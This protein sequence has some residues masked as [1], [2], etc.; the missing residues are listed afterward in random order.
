MFADLWHFLIGKKLSRL[1]DEVL[2]VSDILPMKSMSAPNN[3][4][5][6]HTGESVAHTDNHGDSSGGGDAT[7][8]ENGM[9]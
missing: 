6:N 7:G 1:K 2:T 3:D 4:S 8:R 9:E 5:N